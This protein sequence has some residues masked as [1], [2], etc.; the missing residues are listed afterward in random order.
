[1]AV[2]GSGG[3]GGK[4]SGSA[5]KAGEAFVELS[6]KDKGV[7]DVLNSIGEKFKKAGKMFTGIGLGLAAG[8][9]AV[10][11]P[12]LGLFKEAIER[13]DGIQDVADRMDATTEAVSRLGY[14]AELSASSLE[15]IEGANNIL[16]KAM[17]AASQGSKEQIDAFDK[18]GLS[19]QDLSE[20][21]VDERFLK[22]AEGLDEIQDPLEKDAVLFG[23]FGKSALKLRPLFK[24]GAEGLKAL[25]TEA[26]RAG[27]VLSS[28]DAAKAAK[29]MDSLDRIVKATKYTFLEI[30]MS[31]LG[32]TDQLENSS[33]TIIDFLSHI[34]NF[35]KENRQVIVTVAAVAAG[36]IAAG[37]TI[38]AF[39][40]AIS[41]VVTG[42]TTLITVGSTVLGVVFSPLLIKIALITA[43]FVGLSYVLMELTGTTGDFINAFDSIKGI[44]TDTF[45]AVL[46]ALKASN[47]EL[48]GQIL[49]LA[50]ATAGAEIALVFT[51]MWVGIKN[52]FVEAFHDIIFLFKSYW[53]D[54]STWLKNVFADLGGF[55]LKTMV[56][57]FD[58][59]REPLKK[60]GIQ[61]G[62]EGFTDK[63]IDQATE[64]IKKEH[65]KE[66]VDKARELNE[67]LDRGRENRKKFRENQ[68]LE[69]EDEV[70]KF[71]RALRQLIDKANEPID[72]E[73][74][75]GG[76][77]STN[78]MQTLA[79]AV[80]G[81][82][83]SADF[84]SAL[85][86]GKGDKIGKDQLKEQQKTN[87]KLDD[88]LGM[89]ENGASF[90]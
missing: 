38:T 19:A 13:A 69:A 54:A 68:I 60:I 63:I 33:F 3:G 31:L 55:L 77:W 17:A 71:K 30:G 27:A 67:G 80:R 70:N 65:R 42:I 84:R 35:I 11:A 28:D 85:G 9:T 48:A 25:Y 18:L 36:V 73:W 10:L 29:A 23:I 43:A 89:V 4:A 5:I 44:I 81:T 51:K 41:A 45:E 20:M 12:L 24:D 59:L 39:G 50:F 78:A 26:E 79:D 62:L 58:L 52:T 49:V 47:F 56:K 8:G 46:N 53:N 72:K 88:L 66:N 82:F 75:G 6:A 22:I 83:Q 14:A 86:I 2:G 64:E 74:G 61:L 7:K 32:F 90:T 15:D 34:R 16:T 37:L 40:L 1:M 21:D 57:V 76:D 87:D